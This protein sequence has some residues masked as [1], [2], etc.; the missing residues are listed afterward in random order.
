MGTVHYMSPEQA[1]GLSDVDERTDIWSLGAVMYEMIARRVPFGF[2]GATPTQ[3]ISLIIQKAAP[4]LRQ[5]A[6]I[7]DELQRIVL[8]ALENKRED[9]FQSMKEMLLDLRQLSKQL[10]H[11]AERKRGISPA[12]SE[13]AMAQHRYKTGAIAVLTAM[14]VL[15]AV[16]GFFYFQK[17][18]SAAIGSV[19]V[20]PFINDSHDPSTDYLSDGIAETL[21]NGLSQLPNLKVIS[22]NA[23]FGY[24]GKEQDAK[25]VGKDLNVRA[26]VTGGVKLIGDQVVIRVSLDDASDDHQIWGEQ[27]VRKFTDILTIQRDIAQ[28]VSAN[29]RLKLTGAEQEQLA[30]HYTDSPEGYQLYLKAQY[31]WRKFTQEGLQKGIEYYNQAIARDPNYALAYAGIAAAYV[32]LGNG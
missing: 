10:E 32:V 20:L 13:V 2:D 8:K 12:R 1:S 14:V 26:V 17:G 4:P 30:K 23:A 15:L 6:D 28:Q 21:I 27:Y 5:F 25:K 11:D 3:V 29:L 24:K 9:R 19:A 7:P 18:S 31:E 16:G 22:R